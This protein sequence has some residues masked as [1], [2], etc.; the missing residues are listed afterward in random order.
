MLFFVQN[1]AAQKTIKKSFN[2]TADKIIIE[3]GYIDQ[4]EIITTDSVNKISIISNSENISSSNIIIEE[5]QNKLFIKSI[6]HN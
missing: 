1:L 3:F 4:V 2:S 6:D 5:L